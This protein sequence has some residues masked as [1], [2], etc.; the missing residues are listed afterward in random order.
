MK[1]FFLTLGEDGITDTIHYLEKVEGIRNIAKIHT[2][3]GFLLTFAV[4]QSDAPRVIANLD[5]FKLG[6][7]LSS[8]NIIDIEVSKPEDDSGSS[9]RQARLTI[10]EIYA[11]IVSQNQISFDFVTFLI[12]SSIIAGGGLATN[13][14][15]V[16]VASMLVSPLMGP[17]LAFSLGGIL[18]DTRLVIAGIKNEI[19]AVVLAILMGIFI[20]LLG[21]PL[22]P[23][24]S[25]PTPEMTSRGDPAGLLGGVI[26]ASA[27][28]AAVA[29]AVTSEN[30]AS[31][32]GVAI[33]ASLLPPA[34]N[35]GILFSYGLIGPNF[36][37]NLQYSTND[38]LFM[39]FISFALT[40]INIV[41]VNVFAMIFFRLKKVKRV[42]QN[43]EIWAALPKLN[44]STREQLWHIGS[45]T[46]SYSISN[47]LSIRR[48][49]HYEDVS[50]SSSDSPNPSDH[51]E[52]VELQATTSMSSTSEPESNNVRK[53]PNYGDDVQAWLAALKKGD[54]T[55]NDIPD[56]LL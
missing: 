56:D 47:Q 45:T 13:N 46:P 51:T 55:E 28:G 37:P 50:G 54:I 43:S 32:V 53:K 49:Y 39:S 23:A 19:V 2:S 21:S 18:K 1:Q 11:K 27:S 12:C 10:E 41:L 31:L 14:V 35:V 44:A 7:H 42:G 48:Q 38:L 3:N 16:V 22:G 24:L 6:Y 40:L 15:A 9:S 33:L 29:I 30:F 4:T 20:G 25:W 36:D 17:I 34:V 52:D 8:I 26:I 5:R